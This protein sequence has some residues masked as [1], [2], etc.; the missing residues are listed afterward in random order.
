MPLQSGKS[1]KVISGNISELMHSGRPQAQSIAIA[2]S[3]AGKSKKKKK[4]SKK[5]YN[6]EDIASAREMVRG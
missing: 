4:P 2:M 5:N 3:K 6:R 1:D